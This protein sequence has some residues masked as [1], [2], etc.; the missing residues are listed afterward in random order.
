MRICKLKCQRNLI[1]AKRRLVFLCCKQNFVLTTLA[2]S[3]WSLRYT[4]VIRWNPTISWAG[5]R[6]LAEA[7]DFGL[8]S[9]KYGYF[10][11][12]NTSLCFKTACGAMWSTFYHGRMPIFGLQ[13][14]N[15]HSLPLW[16]LEESGHFYYNSD[17]IRL[18]EESHVHLRWLFKKFHFWVN[19]PFN[20]TFTFMHLADAFIQSNLQ[21]IQAI[22]FFVSACVPWESNPQPLRC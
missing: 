12:T 7:V 14:L 4:S 17:C 13:N 10:S 19:Y 8:Y 11:Y 20:C 5:V 15:P 2:Y 16:S 22:H 21:C 1:Q 9:L 6:Q 3:H 18:K